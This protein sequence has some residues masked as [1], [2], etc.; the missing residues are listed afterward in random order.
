MAIEAFYRPGFQVSEGGSSDFRI[1]QI[2]LSLCSPPGVTSL[3]V[4]RGFAGFT[5]GFVDVLGRG[6]LA[7][8]VEIAPLLGMELGTEYTIDVGA[9]FAVYL[10]GALRFA[11]R[12]PNY[13][14]ERTGASIYRTP[15]AGGAMALGV[16]LNP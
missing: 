3:L 11:L 8:D 1:G 6:E 9:L 7:T 10:R 5:A 4:A 12:S 16:A 13:L 14:D 2:V 15:L